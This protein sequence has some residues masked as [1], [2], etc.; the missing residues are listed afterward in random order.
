MYDWL[1]I[2]FN[3]FLDNDE[4]NNLAIVSSYTALHVQEYMNKKIILN[5]LMKNKKDAEDDNNIA[6]LKNRMDHQAQIIFKSLSKQTIKSIFDKRVFVYIFNQFGNHWN[7]TFL[8][9]IKDYM[10]E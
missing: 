1:S 8:F 2:L 7:C 9:N 4:S 10:L 3:I 6:L 5:A